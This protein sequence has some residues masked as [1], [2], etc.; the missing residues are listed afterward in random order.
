MYKKKRQKKR[1]NENSH[2]ICFLTSFMM[3]DGSD[4]PKNSAMKS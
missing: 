4:N 3:S 2:H 1:N